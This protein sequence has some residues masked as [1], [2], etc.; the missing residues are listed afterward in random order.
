V[1]L[2]AATSLWLRVGAGAIGYGAS[3]LKNAEFLLLFSIVVVLFCNTQMLYR[4]IQIRRALDEAL[5]VVKAVSFA[6][7]VSSATIYLSG[8]RVVSRV[9]LGLTVL[10]TY[11]SLIGWRY[12]RR[13]YVETHV[14][15]GLDC[16]NVLIVGSGNPAQRLE[17]YLSNNKQLGYA[18]KG[19]LD[20][21][22]GAL[23]DFSGSKRLD[24]SGKVVGN[25]TEL[26][27]VVRAQFIDD[28]FIVLPEDREVVKELI[29]QSRM[30]GVSLHVVPDLYDGLALGSP[31]E[32]LGPFPTIQ[33]YEKTMPV[34]GL[35]LKRW[36][37]VIGASVGLMLCLPVLLLIAVAISLDSPGPILYRSQRIGK[38]GRNFNCYKFR[39]MV[40]NADELKNRLRE[41][42]ERDGLLFKIENDPRITPLGRVLRKYSLDE[43]PQLWNVLK[44]DMSLVGPRPPLPGEVSEYELEHFK[45]LEVVPGITGLWQVEARREPSFESYINLDTHYVNNW[46]LWLDLK[47]LLKTI[48]VVVSGTGQ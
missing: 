26:R 2:S 24:T 1:W 8:Q 15:A 21:R 20:R 5:A 47:I 16:R 7:I 4:G 46:S 39:T 19:F 18:V 23:N 43:L 35:I 31:F 3:L 44:G 37:D 14:A 22:N 28:V 10:M 45:R 48:G 12:I 13:R 33:L 17:R 41:F 11:V 25:I 36:V 29:V 27:D 32:Y 34:L 30:S 38:K 6:M 9:V 40:L 42:N